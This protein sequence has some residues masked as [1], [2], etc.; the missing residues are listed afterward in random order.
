M[1]FSNSFLTEIREWKS[2]TL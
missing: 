1:L 2:V